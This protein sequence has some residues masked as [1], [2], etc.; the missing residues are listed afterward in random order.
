[1]E[2]KD[3]REYQKSSLWQAIRLRVIERDKGLC[4]ICNQRGRDCHHIDYELHTLNGTDISNIIL[5]CRKCHDE[6]EFEGRT[7]LIQQKASQKTLELLKG[8]IT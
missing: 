7:K 6:C 5:V 4:R 8:T 3:Y 2:F 1:L